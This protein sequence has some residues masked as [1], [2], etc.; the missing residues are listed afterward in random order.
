MMEEG[1]AIHIA[2]HNN[3][4]HGVPQSLAVRWLGPLSAGCLQTEDL[5]SYMNQFTA[6]RYHQ[7]LCIRYVSGLRNQKL[8]PFSNL[9]IA[10]NHPNLC[11]PHS[12]P[13]HSRDVVSWAGARVWNNFRMAR[14]PIL[15]GTP[16]GPKCSCYRYEVRC[17]VAPLRWSY[18]RKYSALHA[19]CCCAYHCLLRISMV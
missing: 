8:F 6:E 1:T 4:A 12:C 3:L 2:I 18:T 16:P 11:V 7:E 10:C 14:D 15:P 9:P 17:A 13:N 5:G 19:V